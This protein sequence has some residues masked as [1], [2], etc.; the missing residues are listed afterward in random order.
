M[1]SVTAIHVLNGSYVYMFFMT[2]M[3]I[4]GSYAC[5]LL[6]LYMFYVAVIHV[7]CRRYMYVCHVNYACCVYVA[8]KC[9]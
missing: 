1:F 7:L 2:A 3:Y 9:Q 5:P 8:M 4:I 6:Q